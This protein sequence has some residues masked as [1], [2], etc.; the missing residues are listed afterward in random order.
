MRNSLI[1]QIKNVEISNDKDFKNFF[2]GFILL[3]KCDSRLT[4][5]ILNNK[6]SLS[7]RTVFDDSF[8]NLL[9]TLGWNNDGIEWFFLFNV[10][11]EIETLIN[12]KNEEV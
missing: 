3:S 4:V 5:Q 2:I 12:K 7:N 11:D 6:I 8:R 1:E 10:K 9:S